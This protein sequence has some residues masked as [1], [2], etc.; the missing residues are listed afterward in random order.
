VS[1]IPDDDRKQIFESVDFVSSYVGDCNDWVTIKKQIMRGIPSRLRKNFST[2][3]PIT[4]EQNINQ[5]EKDVINYYKE[6]TGMN[7]ILRTLDER[8]E[9]DYVF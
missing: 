2:R 9:L 4:K 6:L 8:R 1:N 5:F 7:L 3:D